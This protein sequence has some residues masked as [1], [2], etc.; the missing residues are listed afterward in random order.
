MDR[1]SS[2]RLASGCEDV[3]DDLKNCHPFL[4]QSACVFALQESDKLESEGDESFG[5]YVCYGIDENIHFVSQTAL[6]DSSF[7]RKPWVLQG[8]IDGPVDGT[9]S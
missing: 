8:C 4:R 1:G 9:F 5:D 7:M 6:S 2:S 3:V